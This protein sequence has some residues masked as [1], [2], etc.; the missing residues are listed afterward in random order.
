MIQT[1]FVLFTTQ[2]SGSTWVIDT[3]NRVGTIAA[4]GELLLRQSRVWDAGSDDY[5]RLIDYPCGR[6]ALRRLPSIR[7]LKTFAYLDGLYG[8]K[9]VQKKG[10]LQEHDSSRNVPITRAVGF[11]LMYS[12]LRQYPE[13]WLYLHWR[14]VR[15]IHLIRQN[16]LDILLSKR[17][18][19]ASGLAHL[20]AHA[21][22]DRANSQGNEP[23]IPITV[24]LDP[25]T[26]INELKWLRNKN[27]WMMHLLRYSGLPFLEV[28]YEALTSTP[29]RFTSILSFLGA[30]IDYH[31]PTSTLQKIRKAPYAET[32]RNYKEI[33]QIVLDSEFASLLQGQAPYDKVSSAYE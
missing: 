22:S 28:T 2:R 24:Y 32:I 6:D 10:T 26:I 4:Y 33:H 15:V 11:K 25:A 23:K 14:K 16:V 19:E 8:K 30:D 29:D 9:D 7:P 17:L 21:D 12:A 5:P 13:V 20:Q 27:R 18:V 31:K 3:L 1:S